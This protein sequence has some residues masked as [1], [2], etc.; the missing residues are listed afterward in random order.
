MCGSEVE[1]AV[2]QVTTSYREMLS[3]YQSMQADQ[4]AIEYLTD[5]WRLLPGDQQVAGVVL[6]DLLDSQDRLA[7]AEL[8]FATALVG[9]NVALIARERAIGTLLSYEDITQVE[10]RRDCL[11]TLLF[12]KRGAGAT[13][14]KA[15][16]DAA[17]PLP[18][19]IP[20]PA[21]PEA[22]RPSS[23]TKVR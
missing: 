7:D 2:R 20:P 3:K 21:L 22:R 10:V 17:P 14:G 13:L 11:P 18:E 12:N 9:Y 16:A 4:A 15:A 23:T 1:I 6:E 19:P 5:R 8:G